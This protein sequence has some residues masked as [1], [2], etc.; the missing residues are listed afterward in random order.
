MYISLIRAFFAAVPATIMSSVFAGLD[1]LTPFQH[2]AAKCRLIADF[3]RPTRSGA[4]SPSRISVRNLPDDNPK[5]S[6][7]SKSSGWKKCI[8]VREKEEALAEA[9]RRKI[10]E[11][12]CGKSSLFKE[13]VYVKTRNAMIAPLS[14]SVVNSRHTRVY[15]FGKVIKQS[16][17]DPRFWLVRFKNKGLFYVSE[18][19]VTFVES[20]APTHVLVGDKQNKISLGKI[21]TKVIDKANILKIIL[22]GKIHKVPG[23]DDITYESLVSLF[24]D[25][26]PWLTVGKLKYH[27]KMLKG[28]I[29]SEDRNSWLEYLSRKDSDKINKTTISSS[30]TTQTKNFVQANTSENSSDESP[31]FD[32]TVDLALGCNTKFKGTNSSDSVSMGKVEKTVGNLITSKMNDCRALRRYDDS[33]SS[34]D[35]S[36]INDATLPSLLEVLDLTIVM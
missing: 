19:V 21:N 6:S 14:K 26:H 7:R 33:S 32:E 35:S 34:S 18:K 20:M 22:C 16:E 10:D 23:H 36:T 9:K 15:V 30:A 24:Q 5:S 4:S 29:S 27:A 3:G 31:K 25:E 1:V 12:L 28:R 8:T 17:I 13:G 11:A 2:E